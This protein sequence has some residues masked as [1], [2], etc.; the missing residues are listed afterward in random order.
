MDLL[1]NVLLSTKVLANSI[2]IFEFGGEWSFGLN[3]ATPDFA[4]SL[5]ILEGRCW[6]KAEVGICGRH[7]ALA[8]VVALVPS[9]AAC[10]TKFGPIR[11]GSVPCLAAKTAPACKAGALP[12]H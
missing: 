6:F 4:C 1:G 8:F 10:S 12:H 7:I 5:T 9:A 3:E 2:G 11:I